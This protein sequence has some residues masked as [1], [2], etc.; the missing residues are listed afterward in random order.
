M[1]P[2]LRAR[3]GLGALPPDLLDEPFEVGRDERVH[4]SRIVGDNLRELRGSL[5]D[6]VAIRLQRFVRRSGELRVVRLHRTL[7][8]LG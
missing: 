4:H 3:C 5:R 7:L 8:L 6:A 1:R 2:R